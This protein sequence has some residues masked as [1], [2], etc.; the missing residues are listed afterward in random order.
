MS[1]YEGFSTQISGITRYGKSYWTKKKLIPLLVKFKPVVIFDYKGEYDA[2]N[3]EI[4]EDA[5]PSWNTYDNILEFFD[6]LS[7]AKKLSKQ[8]HVIRCRDD[9]DYNNGLA[10]MEHL[11]A[12][13]TI[14]LDEAQF[15]FDDNSLSTAAKKLKK[16]VRAGAGDGTDV[17]FIAQRVMDIQPNIRSQF[18][19][20]ITFRQ[21]HQSDID[22]MITDNGLEEAEQAREL[23]KREFLILGDFPSH[24]QGKLAQMNAKN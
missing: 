5:D 24:L 21:N 6:H 12:E 18:T 14:I 9:Y 13:V 1:K 7:E 4:A 16:L 17:I 20:R 19:R 8:V 2:A 23:N 10:F 22:V 15:I 3:G 11:R